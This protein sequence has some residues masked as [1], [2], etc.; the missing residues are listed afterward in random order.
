MDP[1]APPSARAAGSGAAIRQARRGVTVRLGTTGGA[2]ARDETPAAAVVGIC[3]PDTPWLQD[4]YPTSIVKCTRFRDA[5]HSV[6]HVRLNSRDSAD[7]LPGLEGPHRSLIRDAVKMALSV[8]TPSVD[9]ILARVGDVEPWELHRPEVWEAIDPFVSELTGAVLVYPDMGGPVSV[10]PGTHLPL[11]QRVD[12]LVRT[13]ELIRERWAERYQVALL[14]DPGVHGDDELRLLR[15]LVGADAALVRWAGSAS[16]LA[17]HGWRSGAA[18]LAGLLAADGDEQGRTLVGRKVPLAPGRNQ[19]RGRAARLTMDTPAAVEDDRD[20]AYV[21]LQ[22]AEGQDLAR[23]TSEPSFRAPVGA[24]PFPALRV[25]KNIH[26]LI[27]EQAER[28]VFQTVDDTQAI[29]LA[30]ALQKAVRPYSGR[31]LLVGPDGEGLP[32]IRGGASKTPDRPSLYATVAAYLRPWSQSI[33][34]R[35]SLRPGAAPS[36]EAG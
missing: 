11:E 16:D 26:R 22:I 18:A 15:G 31:G 8:G 28:F 3:H 6:E 25:V 36:L 21:E 10:G 4:L 30:V 20:L 17:R 13:T 7:G 34:V 29:A 27:V 19:P 5:A 32:D 1:F 23:V 33:S 2:A 35:V 14:D 9:V 24:W 12:R